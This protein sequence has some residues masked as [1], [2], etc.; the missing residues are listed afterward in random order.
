MNLT[1]LTAAEVAKIK[2]EAPTPKKVR[3]VIVSV[4]KY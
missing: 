4:L 2:Q 3:I 1:M